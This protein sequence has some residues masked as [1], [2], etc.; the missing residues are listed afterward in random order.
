[1]TLYR[2][3]IQETIAYSNTTMSKSKTI[4]DELMRIREDSL[5]RLV[6]KSG[7]A[8]LVLD[9]VMDSIMHPVKEQIIFVDEFSGR[10][11]HKDMLTERIVVTDKLQSKLLAKAFIT[12]Q[13]SSQ[14]QQQDKQ[15]VLS[16]D[17]VSVSENFLSKKFT[18]S[19]INEKLM[20]R[21]YNKAKAYLTDWLHEQFIAADA[22]VRQKVRTKILEK[23]VYQEHFSH[24]K[25][26]RTVVN[27][28]VRII[29]KTSVKYSDMV[30]ERVRFSE[31]YSQQLI[32]QQ[33]ITDLIDLGEIIHQKRKVK[34]RVN[35]RLTVEELCHA[36]SYAK[37]FVHDLLFFEDDVLGERYRGL[38]WTANADTWAMSRYEGYG[39]HDLTVIDGVL[40]GI[41][42]NGVFRIDAKTQQL[43]G[44]VVTGK[45]D[46]GQGGLVHPVG[47]YFEY[48]LSGNSRKLEVGVSTTQSGDKQTYYYALPKE[49][50]DH[51]TNGR[52]LFGRGLRGRHFSFDVKISGE[53]G[54][55]NDLNIDF[56]ATKRRV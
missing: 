30:V 5:Y 1:M 29:D 10:K 45:M 33:R 37:Q 14:T 36:K 16:V 52:V 21:D 51:L 43:D 8:V 6:V 42:D 47:A 39:F 20:L 35:E 44:R 25:I 40:Y 3:D 34:Q 4:T 54:Y 26:T 22:I 24:K 48:E 38:A 18:I 13:L 11:R 19:H 17:Q 27:D 15:R 53:H 7:D 49:N 9:E 31:Q 12:D 32:A 23:I 28:V 46:L 41:N 50:A 56:T 2:D 55:I